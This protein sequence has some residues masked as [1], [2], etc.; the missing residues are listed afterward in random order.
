MLTPTVGDLFNY[1]AEKIQRVA[2]ESWPGTPVRL[3]VHVPSVTGYVRSVSVGDRTLYAKYSFLG[4]SLV[5]VL[6]GGCGDWPAVRAAQA[7][8]IATPGSLLERES[9][10]LRLLRR[11][12]LS[13]CAVAGYRTGVLFTEPV[14]G[15]TLAEMLVKSPDRTADLLA[16]SMAELG[17]IQGPVMA[18]RVEGMRIPERS[19]AGT[20]G[21]KF[22]GISGHTYLSRLGEDRME[23]AEARDQIRKVLITVV[24]RLVRLRAFPQAR[25]PVVSYGDL[26]PEHVLFPEGPEETPT[27]IDPGLARGHGCS[28][29]AKL[30]SRT[31]LNLL[32]TAPQ[33]ATAVAVAAG[34]H[35]FV[36]DQLRSV[37]R[38]MHTAWLRQLLVTWLM[39]TVNILTTYL[40]APAPLPLP[41][42]AT[43]VINRAATVC[44]LLDRTSAALAAG[45]PARA[46]LR[47]ALSDIAKAA[48]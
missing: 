3:G 30:I 31:A 41:E 37:E 2:Q 29:T 39:D 45:T 6:R 43:A 48:R 23:S 15:P 14:A 4:V 21:R 47:L 46:V 44:V 19:I 17:R 1:A 5:S 27:Y 28:D 13:V 11:Q 42:H 33:H 22:N 9:A 24:Q 36:H 20:F 40:S 16:R 26:K 7:A 34:L 10:Q 32:T 25:C 38:G 35:T 8:Y 18:D 12:R